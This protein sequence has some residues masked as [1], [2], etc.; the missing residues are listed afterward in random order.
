[1][2]KVTANQMEDFKRLGSLWSVV[3]HMSADEINGGPPATVASGYYVAEFRFLLPI[4][5]R[6]FSVG[7]IYTTDDESYTFKSHENIGGV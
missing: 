3:R 2:K 4:V 1:M 6:A 7:M 5:A